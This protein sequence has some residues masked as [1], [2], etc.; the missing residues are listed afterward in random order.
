M[1]G[2][3]DNNKNKNKVN[4]NGKRPAEDEGN[5]SRAI[6]RRLPEALRQIPREIAQSTTASNGFRDR[7]GF[8]GGKQ[9]F[10]ILVVKR[11][12]MPAF[13][14]FKQFP[15]SPWFTKSMSADAIQQVQHNID[16]L[17]VKDSVLKLPVDTRMKNWCQL[18]LRYNDPLI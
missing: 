8:M 10:D 9:K 18:Q 12:N 2:N 6:D 5:R 14:E 4:D 1:A 3:N 17:G 11:R 16:T 13:V 15:W 7:M